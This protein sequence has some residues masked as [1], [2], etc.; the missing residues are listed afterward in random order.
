MIKVKAVFMTDRG[1]IRKLNEDSGGI[2]KNKDGH[3]LAIVADGMGGHRAGDVASEMALENMR[4]RWIESEGLDTAELA[5]NW[6]EKNISEINSIIYEY[7]ASNSECEGM[8]TT[9][10]AAITNDRFATIANIGDSRCYI[11]ND[12][13]LKQLTEDH[14]LV[15]ELVRSGQISK[16]DAENHPRK[17]VLLRALGTEA[18]VEIDIKTIMFEEGDVLLLC[19]DG[20]TNKVGEEEIKAILTDDASLDEKARSFID[21]ANENGGEDNIT[22]LILEYD[23]GSERG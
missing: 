14:S 5:E 6:L 19:S 4:Q 17:N 11:L 8:G 23:D 10:V 2:F 7:A 3:R 20:L 15:N 1:R 13:G 12:A 22:L 16:E 21:L 9:I 18:Q